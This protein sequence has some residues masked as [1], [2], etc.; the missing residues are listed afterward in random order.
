MAWNLQLLH[1]EEES[2]P[3]AVPEAKQQ[4]GLRRAL[5]ASI[6][7]TAAATAAVAGLRPEWAASVASKAIVFSKLTCV[8]VSLVSNEMGR[9]AFG[10]ID[11]H[12]GVVG[13]AAI[14]MF[15][16]S[17]CAAVLYFSRRS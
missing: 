12:L 7:C 11:P 4:S 10:A 8:A 14:A 5:A 1:H 2:A 17:A 16:A 13:N 9:L 15:S 3:D 6:I